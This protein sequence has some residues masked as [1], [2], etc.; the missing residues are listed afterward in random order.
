MDIVADRPDAVQAA[1]DFLG[2]A[3]AMRALIEAE[4]KA[5]EDGGTLSPKVVEALREAGIF[6]MNVPREVGGAGA[7]LVEAMEVIEEVAYA[8]ASTGWSLMANQGTIVAAAVYL[9]EPGIEAIFG[10]RER[11][12]LAGMLGPAGKSTA[13]DGGYLG[14]GRFAFGSGMAHADW[15]GAGMFV[16]EEG[17][18]RILAGAGPEVRVCFV[19][20]S[21]VEVL[22][23][24]SP[25]GL[26]GTGSYDYV[27][28][29]QFVPRGFSFERTTLE[30]L[31]GGPRFS[32]GLAVIGASGHAGVAL[33]LM[34]RAL[35]ELV[36]IVS[37]KKR[38]GYPGPVGDH[39]VFKHH[40]ALNEAN[41]QGARDYTFRVFR[42]IETYAASG[43]EPTAEQR[44]RVRQATTWVHQVAGDVVRF[45][46]LWSGSEVI[47]RDSTLGRLSRDM[48][49]A[50]QHVVVDPITLVDSAIVR[51]WSAVGG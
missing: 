30:P 26:V 10:G 34:K 29:E 40:F 3:R 43:R 46:H 11:P 27:V 49:I 7:S 22:G 19:P 6:W 13:E 50:T 38:P 15:I 45:A 48:A 20:K 16:M 1:P 33:G 37:T 32:V 14:G 41:Y 17:R 25:P 5:T 23:G 24:W 47:R 36:A 42:E 12:I 2:Q 21:Q 39:D 51:A 28:P 9:G 8:D 44:A 18:P 31:R 35:T 4:A